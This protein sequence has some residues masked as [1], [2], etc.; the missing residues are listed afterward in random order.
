MSS[1]SPA[2]FRKYAKYY[3]AIYSD[4][5]YEKETDILEGIFKA[6]CRTKPRTILDAGCGTGNHAIS[7]ASRGY[8]VTGVDSSEAM[9]SIAKEKVRDKGLTIEL[10]VMDLT[11]LELMEKFDV[12]ICMFAVIGYLT[13]NENLATALR[14][15]RRHLNPGSLFVFDFWYGPAVLAIRPSSRTKIV[16]ENGFKLI[17]AVSPRLDV[18]SH[19][20]E[21]N[22]YLVVI[23]DRTVVDEIME[24]HIVRFFFSQELAHYISESGFELLRISEFLNPSTPPSESS[25]NAMV[26]ARAS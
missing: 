9:I 8:R 20:C 23:K 19:T 14:N 12:C 10:R 7:L 1:Y 15:I 11:E 4:K 6:H 3:D 25:W 17:R 22:Y 18:A 16:E 5:D 24:S 26:I 2:V 13:D 21:S